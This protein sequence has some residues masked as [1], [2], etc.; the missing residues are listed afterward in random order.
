[1]IKKLS[2]FFFVVLLIGSVN[3]IGCDKEGYKGS[4]TKGDTINIS[5]SCPTC[6]YVNISVL[7]PDKRFLFVNEGM[8]KI[9]YLFWYEFNSTQTNK[10]GTY[11]IDGYSNLDTPLGLC[12][13]VT[14]TG[15][16]LTT[17]NSIIYGILN[18]F[19]FVFFILC[20]YFA[21]RIPYK[22]NAN[23]KGAIIQ[24]TKLKYIKIFM[25]GL[26]Y[27]MFTWLLNVLIALSDNYSF[28][29]QYYGLISFMFTTLNKLALPFGIFLIV[30]S[31]FE[32][33]RD[34]NIQKAIE[35]YGSS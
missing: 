21:I 6:T 5:V 12:F 10:V 7:D 24:V 19:V 25:I 17:G 15:E 23:E 9:G 13:E 18:L 3:A 22:N 14:K 31:F 29:T 28:L 35:R 32:I 8:N 2:V 33:I 20:L 11:F 1:M 16:T 30:L 26:T 4:V 27:V 34:A